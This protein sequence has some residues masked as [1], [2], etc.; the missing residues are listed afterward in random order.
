MLEQ[1]IGQKVEI[2]F[3]EGKNSRGGESLIGTIVEVKDSLI[4]LQDVSRRRF[5]GDHLNETSNQVVNCLS[6]GFL[7]MAIL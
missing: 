1:L 3:V 4:Y 2:S 5:T 6:S 7:K